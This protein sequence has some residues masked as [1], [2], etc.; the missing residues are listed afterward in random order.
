M[1]YQFQLQNIKQQ[2]GN[3]NN[4][5]DDL[6]NQIQ[7]MASS[8]VYN[9]A[10]EIL[11]IG[12]SLIKIG[13]QIPN[14]ENDIFNYALQIESI[15]IQIQNYGN[16]IKNM[17]NMNNM[18]NNN[19]INLSMII[20][21]NNIMMPNQML[22][23]NLMGINNNDNDWFKGFKM[24]VEE[25]KYIEEIEKF[26]NSPKINIIFKTNQG[27]THTLVFK[28]GTT[29]DEVLKKYCHRIKE[30]EFI[31][32]IKRCFLFNASRLKFGDKT[33]I[34]D[35]FKGISNPKVVVNDVN[36]LK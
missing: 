23:L 1:N 21:D 14:K 7:N 5:F 34:E 32:K 22:G 30:L 13:T 2:I 15:G 36:N 11:N 18:N 12:I 26:D 29:I 20:P 31:C 4:Q 16:Q 10:I 19:N 8:N 3:I 25:E 28:Y 33:K 27:V 9:I 35:F 17:N 24:G 6:M